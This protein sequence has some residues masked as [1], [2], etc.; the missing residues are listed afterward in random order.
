[1]FEWIPF[2]LP[3]W[4]AAR[5]WKQTNPKGTKQAFIN[6]W[7]SVQQKSQEKDK[8]KPL[9]RHGIYLTVA[10]LTNLFFRPVLK[11]QSKTL[12][13]RPACGNSNADSCKEHMWVEGKV[14]KGGK[15]DRS[16]CS[17]LAPNNVSFFWCERAG[18]D[19]ILSLPNNQIT[20]DS[21]NIC[22]TGW[23]GVTLSDKNLHSVVTSNYIT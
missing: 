8:V 11:W 3:R 2:T 4:D 23:L 5:D 15:E 17:C 16:T 20:S 22:A 7:D 19:V 10:P 6:F 13:H 1:M 9:V 18:T 12:C 14:G 21:I